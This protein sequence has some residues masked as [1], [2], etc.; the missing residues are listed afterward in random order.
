[1]NKNDLMKELEKDYTRWNDVY[2]NGTT[3]PSWEDGFNLNLI[4]NHILI[5]KQRLERLLP[6]DQLPKLYFEKDPPEVNNHYMAKKEKILQDAL[7]YYQECIHTEGWNELDNV[8][9]FLDKNDSEQKTMRFLVS[10]IRGLKS[11]IN[12]L[13]YVEM[14]KFKDPSYDIDRIKKLAQ[15]LNEI[16]IE[17]TQQLTLFRM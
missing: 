8:F 6:Q 17:G 4:R 2:C 12:R 5:D 15:R 1:M 3:D 14:R 10:R 9:D 7:E 16:Q 13:N 11:S